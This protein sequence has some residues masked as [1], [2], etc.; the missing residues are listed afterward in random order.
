MILWLLE[1]PASPQSIAWICFWLSIS[2]Q[3]W[4]IIRSYKRAI[5]QNNERRRKGFAEFEERVRTEDAQVNDRRKK[6]L[7]LSLLQL[8]GKN[9]LT[10]SEP[11]ED[12][13]FWKKTNRG[14]RI[15][16]NNISRRLSI[17]SRVLISSLIY[18]TIY[19]VL[20]LSST[21]SKQ[22]ISWFR[23]V[24]QPRINSI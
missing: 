23:S 14:I 11:S 20:K 17:F 12:K 2:F 1:T 19:I 7:G 24:S 22:C 18:E 21:T 6:I 3:P 5:E 4:G 10:D 16:E 9:F 15:G 13:I 8:R